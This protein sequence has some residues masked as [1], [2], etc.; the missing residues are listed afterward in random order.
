MK[1]SMNNMVKKVAVWKHGV[2][3]KVAY[4]ME[5]VVLRLVRPLQNQQGASIVEILGYALIAVLAIV[6]VWGLIK[7]WLPSFWQSITGRL[8]NLS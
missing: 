4:R 5:V 1:T 7:G 2:E 3:A 8:D 6:V